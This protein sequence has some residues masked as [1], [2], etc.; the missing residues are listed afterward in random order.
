VV[1]VRSLEFEALQ[2]RT[3]LRFDDD[4]RFC[5]EVGFEE[6]DADVAMEKL[7]RNFKGDIDAQKLELDR[8]CPA[9]Y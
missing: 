6:T 4:D 9:I 7:V 5:Y 2:E 1:G 3:S 8:Q